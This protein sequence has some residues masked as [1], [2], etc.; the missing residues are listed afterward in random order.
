MSSRTAWRTAL[1]LAALLSLTGAP[2]AAQAQP[3]TL[4]IGQPTDADSV[5]RTRSPR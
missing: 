5:D 2:P 4:I 1:T 3:N